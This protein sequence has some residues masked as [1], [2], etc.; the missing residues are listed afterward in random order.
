MAPLGYIDG[1]ENNEALLSHQTGSLYTHGGAVK[2]GQTSHFSVT[3]IITS[4]V[5]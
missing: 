3:F 1:V 4:T 2:V 5:F